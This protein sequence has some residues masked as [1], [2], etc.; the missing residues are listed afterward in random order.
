VSSNHE[1]PFHSAVDP[2]NAYGGTVTIETIYAAGAR[3][4]DLSCYGRGTTDD[5]VRNRDIT[6]GFH[7][8][9]HRSDYVAYLGVHRLPDPPK[10]AIDMTVADFE[11]A[12]AAF[13][14]ELK[15][16]FKAMD[17]ESVANTDEFAEILPLRRH[18][19]ENRFVFLEREGRLSV[20]PLE[21]R[22]HR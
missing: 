18:H 16:Y 11:K 22:A 9:C 12:T 21:I 5:D 8:S 7:E 19:G 2:L 20:R 15:A 3:P 4:D 1:W 10:L 17:A 6:L 14:K 13:G